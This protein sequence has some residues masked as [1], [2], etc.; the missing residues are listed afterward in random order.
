MTPISISPLVVIGLVLFSCVKSSPVVICPAAFAI[1]ECR[2]PGQGLLSIDCS[3]KNL[4]EFP[5]Q[6]D[7]FEVSSFIMM[8]HM[9][10]GIMSGSSYSENRNYIIA[11][12]N[13]KFWK[14]KFR[15][16]ETRKLFKIKVYSCKEYSK[17]DLLHII[18]LCS[19][20]FI[21]GML[22]TSNSSSISIEYDDDKPSAELCH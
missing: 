17:F 5:D 3:R 2:A 22:F 4:S 15:W 9:W 14:N 11:W 16:N 8:S 13:Q 7:G 10:A 19:L 21:G 6:L 18:T 1:C 12:A 20:L